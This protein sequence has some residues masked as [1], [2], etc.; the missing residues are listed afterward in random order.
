ML[1]EYGTPEKFWAEAINTA[2]HASNQ[3]YIHRLL[4]KT[5]YE[6]L[7]RKKASISYLRVFGSKCFIYKKKRLGKFESRCDEGFFLGYASNSKAYR[8]FNKISRLVEE[9][10]YVEFDESN[11]SQGEIV[12]YENIGDDEVI[13]ALKNMSIRDIKPEGCK[14]IVTKGDKTLP[15]LH[16]APPRYPK[17][18]K[19]KRNITHHLNWMSKVIQPKLKINMN[20]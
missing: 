3:V 11:G 19:M 20:Q 15:P 7:I 6:L 13:E 14:K 16:Q 1:D 8:V 9:T 12:C 2:C 17:W 5:S 18:M 4:E 10:C